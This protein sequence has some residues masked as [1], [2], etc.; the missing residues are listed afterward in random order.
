MSKV[1]MNRRGEAFVCRTQV[2]YRFRVITTT[3]VGFVPFDVSD[4]F[5]FLGTKVKKSLSGF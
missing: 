1:I 4:R 5:F 2:A 3:T